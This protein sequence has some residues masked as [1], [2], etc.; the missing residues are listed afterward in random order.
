MSVVLLTDKTDILN[1]DSK[2][3]VGKAKLWLVY[4]NFHNT[5]N[6]DACTKF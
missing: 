5:E 1:T 3:F 4:Q 2:D 6:A